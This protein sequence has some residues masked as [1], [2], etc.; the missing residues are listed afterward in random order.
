MYDVIVAG[1][2]TAGAMAAMAAAR[3]G[4]KVLVLEKNTY[5]GGTFTG[6]YIC[7]YYDN[8]LGGM[9]E[10]MDARAAEANAHGDYIRG[11]GEVKK[12]IYEQDMLAHGVKI[13]YEAV[14]TGVLCRDKQVYG[15]VWH[16]GT[17]WHEEHGRY[18][19]DCTA[20]ARICAMAG[21]ELVH[22]RE[23]DGLYQQF[24]NSAVYLND[25]RAVWTANPDA[26]RVDQNNAEE[27]SRTMLETATVHLQDKFT[28]NSHRMLAANDIPGLREGD[29]IVPETL[30]T[31]EEFLNN[32]DE[33]FEPVCWSKTVIDT[34]ANDYP[35]ESEIFQDWMIGDSMWATRI[36]FGVPRGTLVP[37]GF[38]GILA[39]GRHVGVDHDMGY[40]IRMNGAMSRLGEAAGVLAALSI[41]SGVSAMAVP[42]VELKEAL[43]LPPSPLGENNEVWGLDWEQIKNGLDSDKPGF[44]AWSARNRRDPEPLKRWYDESPVGSELRCHSAFALALMGDSYGIEELRRM[45]EIRDS[46]TPTTGRK[47]NH[48]RG[49]VALYFLGKLCDT[50]SVELICGVLREQDIINKYG[51]HSHAVG[52]L[53]KIGD[54]HP[55]L[56]ERIA[57]Q[58]RQTAEDPEWQIESRHTD[59]VFWRRDALF[60]IAIA[61]CLKRW[62][63]PHHIADAMKKLDLRLNE[64]NLAGRSLWR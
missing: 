51:F 60:R 10:E 62:G 8:G 1:C 49:Y 44:A 42:Y 59:G 25:H 48:P 13:V 12:L 33:V 43:K 45:V 38:Q 15:I 21:C 56:R 4:M 14:I 39:A 17:G 54:K 52:A 7:G 27:F 63:I 53:I 31:L 47:Y 34:H 36:W 9:V 46:Y 24:T 55:E 61:K 6:G 18:I 22:G 16:D 23:A 20:D 64:Y 58:L 37:R 41:K 19:I 2:G 30:L 11:T 40:A 32:Q 3:L 5:P 57:V 29:R 50:D 35:L 28:D 26:G